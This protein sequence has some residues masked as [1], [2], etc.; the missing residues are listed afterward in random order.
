MDR[1]IHLIHSPCV[2]SS[3]RR[4][5]R[6]VRR[7]GLVKSITSDMKICYKRMSRAAMQKLRGRRERGCLPSFDWRKS[8]E[9]LPVVITARSYQREFFASDLA[10]GL[11]E[12]RGF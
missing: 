2:P 8:L 11:T 1:F 12:V 10:A 5:P 6:H 3:R 9:A 7:G 4:T